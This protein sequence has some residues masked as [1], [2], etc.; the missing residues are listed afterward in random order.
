MIWNY[1]LF[2]KSA[3]DPRVEQFIDAL[4]YNPETTPE[5]ASCSDP[6]FDAAKSTPG[7]PFNG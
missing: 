3:K 4:K 2:V 5:N 7:H 6:V 1:Q